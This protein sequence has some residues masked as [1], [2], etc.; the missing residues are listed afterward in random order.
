MKVETV[1]HQHESRDSDSPTKG[2]ECDQHNGTVSDLQI[3][4]VKTVT[5]LNGGRRSDLGYRGRFMTDQHEG[6][7]SDLPT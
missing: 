6:K 4:K 5:C 1:T 3:L 7:D 2:R